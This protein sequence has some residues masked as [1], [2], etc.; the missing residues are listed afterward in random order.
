MFA[1]KQNSKSGHISFIF[2]LL[3]GLSTC[4]LGQHRVGDTVSNFTLND[5]NGNL[6]S[7][8]DFRGKVILLNFFQTT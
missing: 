1:D 6:V 5:V 3:L 8:S 2:L 7:L 4:V